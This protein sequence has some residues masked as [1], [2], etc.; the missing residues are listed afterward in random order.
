MAIGEQTYKELRDLALKASPA[1]FGMS[2]D[3]SK[4][5]AYGILMETGYPKATVTLTSY[6]SGDASLY[7]SMGGGI[8]GGI[9][10]ESVRIA[11]KKFVDSAQRF[12]TNM[13]Q[14]SEFP[15]PAV[16]KTRFYVITNRGIYGS[17]EFLENDLGNR[18][19]AFSPLFY[20]GQN[21]ISEIRLN[22]RKTP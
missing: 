8:I 9:G 1:E 11:A 14:A 2:P 20:D 3:E 12:L 18:K 7:F 15:S 17:V 22:Q 21:V 5:I 13:N 10:H 16:G 4:V 6:V 19:S